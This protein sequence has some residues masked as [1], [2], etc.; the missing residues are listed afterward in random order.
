MLFGQPRVI[1][2]D[3]S[4]EYPL[5]RKTL[6]VLGYLILKSKR[7]PTRDAVAFALFP[8]EDEEKARGSLRRNLSYLLSSL[9]SDQGEP[10]VVADPER[11]SWNPAA[12]A[13]VDVLAFERAIAEGRDDDALAEYTGPLLPTL[14]DEWTTADRERL[15]EL[16]HDALVRTIA[17][18]RSLRRYDA[19]LASARR[20][21]DDDPWRED[22]VRQVMSVRYEAGDRAGALATFAQFAVRM[23]DEMSADPM[24]ETFA[25]REA[26]L[27]GGRLATSEPAA[28]K[29]AVA[30]AALPFVG[31]GRG[32]AQAIDRWH[33]S[34]D[35]RAG[36]LFV[37][38]EAGIGKSRFAAE[39]ARAIEREGG[40][41]IIGDTAAGGERRPYEAVIEALR[42]AQPVRSMPNTRANDAWSAGI[43]ELLDI[44]ALAT[45]SDDRSARVRLFGAMQSAFLKLARARPLAVVLEDL[46]WA[47]RDTIDLIGY[48]IDRLATAPVLLIATYRDDELPRPHPLRG[49]VND[50]ERAGRA[51]RI[52][53]GRLDEADGVRAATA[54]APPS[55]SG[56][57]LEAAVAWSEGVPLLLSEAVRDLAAGRLFSGGDFLSVIADRFARLGPEAETALNYAAVLGARFELAALAAATGWRD[58]ALVDALGPSLELGIVRAATRGH[59][60]AFAFS[61]HVIHAATL[62]RIAPPDVMRIHAL[63]ARALQAEHSGGDRASE[64]A[65][66]FAAA[67]ETRRAAEHYARAARYALDVFANADARDAA[68]AGLMLAAS[69]QEDL[70][71]RYDLIA[72]RERAFARLGAAAERRADAMLLSELAR[73]DESRSCDALERLVQALRNDKPARADA[74]AR[75]ESLTR[76]SVRAAAIFDRVVAEEAAYDGDWRLSSASAERAARH[77]DDLGDRDASIRAQLLHVNALIFLGETAHAIAAV[78]GLR[79]IA[80]ACE[81]VSLRLE[82]HR[83]ACSTGSDGHRDLAV[84]DAERALELALVIGDRYAEARARHGL[85]W[86]AHCAGDNARGMIEYE[87]VVRSL[88]ELGDLQSATPTLLNLAGNLGWFGDCA[89]AL[90]VLDQLDPQALDLPWVAFQ[91]HAHRGTTWLRCGDLDL[92]EHHLRL[93]RDLALQLGTASYAVH[94]QVMLA[95]IEAR[96]GNFARACA[97]LHEATTALVAFALPLAAAGAQALLARIRAELHDEPAAR[98]AMAQA[99]AFIGTAPSVEL[100]KFWWD[101]AA[102]SALLGDE[103]TARDFAENAA[104]MFAAEAMGA[105]ADMVETYARLAWH[106]DIF[107]YLAG[108]DVRLSMRD[109]RV[110][111]N[112]SEALVP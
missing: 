61:H 3:G 68:T 74:L 111:R 13:Y 76:T 15:R 75:L 23:R 27:R 99:I 83:V 104:R 93:A 38:G 110:G 103:A 43:E 37:A 64:I 109:Q 70:D 10:F 53:L 69:T 51:T 96:R 90:R 56:A 62:A 55:V 98:A 34:A 41:A 36:A 8:D 102:A 2:D 46:H 84:A 24:D 91:A 29:R 35:G 20:L 94:A 19:A 5:P 31:R 16:A 30:G 45:L 63:V 28:E 58:D 54:A 87:R 67:G 95:E 112:A 86:A 80:E 12:R 11:L 9:P 57:S 105:R 65:Q 77:F 52:A 78:A 72:T 47:G 39:L 25:L 18:D 22:V 14:Y 106:I 101:L 17:R 81:D 6:N 71:L 92:G 44:H 50:V 107:A 108:R 60:L 48:L 26:M 42:Y 73:G 89:G 7:P 49:L 66:H 82:F 79:P 32:M 4:R 59:S 85:G 21:L 88:S 100:S 97:E 1:A 33:A 40:T